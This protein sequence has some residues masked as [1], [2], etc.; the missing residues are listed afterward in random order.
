LRHGSFHRSTRLPIRLCRA[1]LP[2][3][4]LNDAVNFA[5][6]NKTAS[7][8]VHCCNLTARHK[9]PDRINRHT[10]QPCGFRKSNQF[11]AH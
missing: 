6:R 7:P 1:S 5:F 2:Y 8:D 11:S 10:K 4:A 9:A 3:A